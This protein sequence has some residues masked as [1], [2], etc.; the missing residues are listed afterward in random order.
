[1]H[2]STLA[3]LER[4]VR[5]L[6]RYAAVV[7]L[8]L[9]AVALIAART[10]GDARE[11]TV[12]RINIVDP[13]GVERLVIAN[14]ERFPPPRLGGKTYPRA[15][16]PA[17]LVFYDAKGHEV[18]GIAL[19]DAG[20]GKV[21]ALAFDYPNYDAVGL[22]TRVS[23]DGDEAMAG[24]Q[25]NSR[26]PPELDVIAASKVVQR[27][28]AVMNENEDARILLAD[29]EGRDRIRLQVDRNGE[30]SIEILDADGQVRFRAPQAR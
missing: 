8:A 13:T 5:L 12:E 2:D 7:T 15:V 26:P 11:I 19:T 6:K 16:Q 27:R 30:A 10:P 21:G 1:M 20:A 29:A 9:L 22:V 23:G 17:G 14:A 28:I 3:R 24:L 18:G 25:I 4:D